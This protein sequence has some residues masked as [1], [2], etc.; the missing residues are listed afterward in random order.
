[1]RDAYIERGERKTVRTGEEEGVKG[2]EVGEEEKG[3]V[4]K[5]GRERKLRQRSNRTD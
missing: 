2:R 5:E 4:G 1:M 3:R